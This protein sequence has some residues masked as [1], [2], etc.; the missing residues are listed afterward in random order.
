MVPHAEAMVLDLGVDTV[1]A[2]VTVLHAEV[3]V[4][5]EAVL[6]E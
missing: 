4:Q 1:L 5:A 2:V 6:K 3:M